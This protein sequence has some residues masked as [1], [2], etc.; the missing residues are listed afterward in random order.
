MNSLT[1]EPSP[2]YG[3]TIRLAQAY[4]AARREIVSRSYQALRWDRDPLTDKNWPHFERA[5]RM[6]NACGC[7]DEIEWIQ[8]QFLGSSQADYPYPNNLATERAAKKYLEY[9][10]AVSAPAVI[11][12]QEA[13]IRRYTLKFPGRSI[14]EIVMNPRIIFESWFR[15]WYA[16]EVP[17]RI[18][19]DAE[20]EL[21]RST[22]LRKAITAAGYDLV[23]LEEK[24]RLI[25]S[26]G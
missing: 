4:E 13:W 11:K 25:F 9:S 2:P 24:I 21:R 19:A 12:Q 10:D 14:T 20:K 16:T 17:I 18:A 23:A 5:A 26:Q 6:M 3:R 7:R 1:T 22:A 15:V 8:A